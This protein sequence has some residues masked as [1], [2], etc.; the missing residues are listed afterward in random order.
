MSAASV[1]LA[2]ARTRRSV[3]AAALG[4]TWDQARGRRVAA[5]WLAASSHKGRGL[6]IKAFSGTAASGH[7]RSRPRPPRAP[8]WAGKASICQRGQPR[9]PWEGSSEGAQVA[10]GCTSSTSSTRTPKPWPRST[11]SSSTT[12]T[13]SRSSSSTRRVS[14]PHSRCLAST[15]TS[16][17][18]YRASCQ[19]AVAWRARGPGAACPRS[20]TSTPR[21]TGL[22][23]GTRR[24][25][26]TARAPGTSGAHEES[27]AQSSG[28][29]NQDSSTPTVAHRHRSG[30][31]RS[32]FGGCAYRPT[33][34]I[35]QVPC[36]VSR[37]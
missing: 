4:P 16:R 31:D 7:P 9:R 6:A 30:G 1:Q 2:P 13:T 37:V 20:S 8:P 23:S 11:S 14:G 21:R 32:R 15:S 24:S 12:N 36:A 10:Q 22:G 33:A 29:P 25:T 34:H 5:A 35:S 19:R 26:S 27:S 3:V 18:T 17:T 28:A